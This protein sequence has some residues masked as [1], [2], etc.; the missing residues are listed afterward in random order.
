MDASTPA[1]L[2]V[3]WV[4]A[5]GPGEA[6]R[7]R[8]GWTLDDQG[9]RFQVTDFVLALE[10]L[11]PGGSGPVRLDPDEVERVAAHEMGHA[12]GLGHSDNPG[13]LMYPVNTA[14]ALSPRD[15]RTLQA[16]YRLPPG[17]R[18]VPDGAGAGDATPPPG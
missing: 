9:F 14:R 11:P 18:L 10:V 16:L 17:A 8:S 3:R 12:L 2:Q 6:G 15:Y 7:V 4:Q 5:L 1:D 13:D